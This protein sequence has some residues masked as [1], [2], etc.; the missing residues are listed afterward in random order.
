MLHFLLL[1]KIPSTKENILKEAQRRS[2][3]RNFTQRSD[4]KLA[5]PVAEQG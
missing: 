5:F 4:L 2:R 1:T 3:P